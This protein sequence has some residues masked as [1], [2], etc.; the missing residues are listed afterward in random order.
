M[1]RQWIF[2]VVM[3]ATLGAS[4]TA[5]AASCFN[6]DANYEELEL[7]PIRVTVDGAE[8]EPETYG[9]DVYMFAER[10]GVRVRLQ[11]DSN[12]LDID[13]EPATAEV[14]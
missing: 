6:A 14:E 2:A 9:G 4:G 8:V 11:R 3:V 13:L 5:L 1:S 10:E 7:Q 12:V